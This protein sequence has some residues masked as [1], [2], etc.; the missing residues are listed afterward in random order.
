MVRIKGIVLHLLRI[1]ILITISLSEI[2]H[3]S[4]LYP[5]VNQFLR[6]RYMYTCIYKSI[7]S[8][9]FFLLPVNCG[10]LLAQHSNTD[11][12]IKD[13]YLDKTK[14]IVYISFNQ[15][16]HHHETSLSKRSC[17]CTLLLIYSEIDDIISTEKRRQNSFLIRGFDTV[18]GT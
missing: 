1:D 13:R 7:G 11:R 10:M 3:T 8:R 12:R 18:L 5:M 4:T 15:S 14:P 16:S 6:G 17:T 2:Q 9:L